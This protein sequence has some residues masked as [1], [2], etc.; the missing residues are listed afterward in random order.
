MQKP[1]I[2]CYIIERFM[3][4]IVEW[5]AY[6]VLLDAIEGMPIVRQRTENLR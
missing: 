6:G 4:T 1:V 2:E 5:H 3:G